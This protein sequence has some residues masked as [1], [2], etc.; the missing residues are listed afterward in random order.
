MQPLTGSAG[1]I[2]NILGK[3]EALGVEHLGLWPYPNVAS[4]IDFLAEVVAASR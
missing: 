2:A 1:Q 4:S 3:F